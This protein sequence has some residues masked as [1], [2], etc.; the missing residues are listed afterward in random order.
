MSLSPENKRKYCFSRPL[1]T[2][3]NVRYWNTASNA[4]SF[5]I[6]KRQVKP[7][8]YRTFICHISPFQFNFFYLVFFSF[9]FSFFVINQE[10]TCGYKCIGWLNILKRYVT[11][12]SHFLLKYVFTRKSCIAKQNKKTESCTELSQFLLN[13]HIGWVKPSFL[14]F[15]EMAYLQCTLKYVK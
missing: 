11:F 15:A 10:S 4:Q 9:F 8:I 7:L 13:V 6:K 1:K 5:I 2:D 3:V 12:N 14:Q